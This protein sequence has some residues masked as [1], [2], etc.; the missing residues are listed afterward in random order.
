[1]FGSKVLCMVEYPE[2]AHCDSKRNIGLWMLKTRF[3]PRNQVVAV[4][5]PLKMEFQYSVAQV[6][7]K[8]FKE[9]PLNV[10]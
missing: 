7:S 4:Y 2:D 3:Q 9:T 8:N 1:M 5:F 6:A 10:P